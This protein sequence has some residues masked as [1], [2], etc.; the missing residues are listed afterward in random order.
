MEENV[1][2]PLPPLFLKYMVLFSFEIIVLYILYG[3][4]FVQV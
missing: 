3:F 1:I 4:S 2:L